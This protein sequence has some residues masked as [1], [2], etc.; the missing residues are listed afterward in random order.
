VTC[1]AVWLRNR[2]FSFGD[3]VADS[4]AAEQRLPAQRARLVTRDLI[5]LHGRI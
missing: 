5:C 2:F 1:A 4:R 3:H